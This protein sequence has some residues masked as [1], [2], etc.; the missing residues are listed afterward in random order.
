MRITESVV[1][2]ATADQIWP[3][4]I[5]VARWREWTRS[6]QRVD[7]LDPPLRLGS[8]AKIK[9]PKFPGVVWKVS[10]FEPHHAFT[11]T[12]TSPGMTSTAGHRIE[13]LPDMTCRVTLTLEQS[14]PGAILF[15]PLV[16]KIS[17][18]YVTM[19]ARGLKQRVESLTNAD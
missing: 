6:I 16:S 12:A 19:E 9:Q 3:V 14:G 15:G 2:N 10:S 4:L 8:R 18:R 13:E 1:I 7:V 11:W 5:D 17:R